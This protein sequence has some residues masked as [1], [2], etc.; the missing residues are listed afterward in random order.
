MQSKK[1]VFVSMKIAYLKGCVQ[2][3]GVHENIMNH[4]KLVVFCSLNL[5]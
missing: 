1:K 5:L 3:Q 4:G 2:K